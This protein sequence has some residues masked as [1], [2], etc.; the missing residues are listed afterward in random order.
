[1]NKKTVKLIF[2]TQNHTKPDFCTKT[3]QNAESVYCTRISAHDIMN[4][5]SEKYSGALRQRK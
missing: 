5:V 1:M 3:V 4:A 2:L